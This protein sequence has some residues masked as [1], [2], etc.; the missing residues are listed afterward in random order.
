MRFWRVIA[1]NAAYAQTGSIAGQARDG[2]GAALPGVLVEV[3]GPQLIVP[4]SAT[5]D[6]NGNYL[7]GGLQTTSGPSDEY[8]VWFVDCLTCARRVASSS[9]ARARPTMD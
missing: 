6:E 4:R 3:S 5:T 7:I 1:A 9:S 2:S 8:Y